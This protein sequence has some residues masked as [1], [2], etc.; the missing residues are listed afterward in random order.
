MTLLRKT[1]RRLE[2]KEEDIRYTHRALIESCKQKDQRAYQE[3]YGLYA[4]AMYNTAKRMLANPQDA[5]DAIQES[6]YKAFARLGQFN[7]QSSFGAWLK[8]IVINHC[9]DQQRKRSL[10]FEDVDERTM[11]E[12]HTDHS[13][14]EPQYSVETVKSAMSSLPNGYRAILNLYLFEGYT[15][16]EIGEILNISAQTS[17]SQYHR[18]KKKLKELI[19]QSN[20]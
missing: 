12:M 19:A 11:G 6:F 4:S 10:V 2:S 17:K 8:R 18:A 13:E 7:Y 1:N 14:Q 15:H 9:L 20:G 3:V 16:D 5:Q